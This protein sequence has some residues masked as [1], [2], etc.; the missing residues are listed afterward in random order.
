MNKRVRIAL[1]AAA[2]MLAFTAGVFAADEIRVVVDGKRLSTNAIVKDGQVWAPVRTVAEALGA[3]V[4]WDAG[5]RT[6][7]VTPRSKGS[8]DVWEDE[9][10][11]GD[12]G[13]GTW[14]SIR[15]R[16][17]EFLIAFDER[18]QEAGRRLVTPD[19]DS[20]VVGSETV[21]PVGGVYPNFADF[22]VVDVTRIDDRKYRARVVIVQWML[23]LRKEYW[24]FDLV[25]DGE[26]KIAGIRHAGEESLDEYEVFPGM[27]LR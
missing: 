4:R 9:D 14:I 16:I 3:K 19:F 8:T 20:D 26:M 21:I 24:D 17:A 12:I 18:N 10:V 13:Y 15:N 22:Q 6:V 5:T 2:L 25:R 1:S 27:T 7:V 11:L 23:G